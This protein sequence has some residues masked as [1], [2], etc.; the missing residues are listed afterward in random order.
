MNVERHNWWRLKREYEP[1]LPG[2]H[3]NMLSGLIA[4]GWSKC[5]PD[6]LR[7]RFLERKS[8]VRDAIW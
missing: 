5:A 6:I 2:R 8:T 4:L 3:A 1:R 7:E